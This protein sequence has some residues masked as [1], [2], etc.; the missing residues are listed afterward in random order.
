M[1]R[2]D[3]RAIELR[4]GEPA[5]AATIA[6]LALQVFLDTYATEGVRPDLAREAFRAY[7]EQAF[8]PR[9]R[10][11]DRSF[12]LAGTPAGLLGF[13]EL[14]A[15]VREAPIAGFSGCELV[16]LYV[17]PRAQR[18]GLGTALLQH[19]QALA[20][21]AGASHL[22]LTVWVGNERARAFYQAKGYTDVGATVHAFEGRTYENRVVTRRL[23]T[24]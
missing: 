21:A 16:R 1:A 18:S 6:A 23:P 4:R 22:W 15:S 11:P 20:L 3:R 17:Q 2:A 24:T 10:D 19:A 13:A 14:H 12:V 5:D 7:S 8:L 9:L